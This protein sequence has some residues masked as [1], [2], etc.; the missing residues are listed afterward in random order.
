MKNVKWNYQQIIKMKIWIFILVIYL[1][2]NLF[3]SYSQENE[4][5]WIKLN[6]S[7][8]WIGNCIR[9]QKVIPSISNNNEV[10]NCNGIK[11]N[12]NVKYI[13]DCI[14]TKSNIS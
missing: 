11:L 7:I 5:D 3:F 8:Q 6:S 1:T 14:E 2:T 10:K 9:T 4:C 13:W 12:S